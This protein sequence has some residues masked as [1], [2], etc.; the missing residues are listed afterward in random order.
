[1]PDC[2]A[3]AFQFSR[4]KYRCLD[5]CRAPFSFVMQYRHGGATRGQAFLLGAYHGAF[6]VG[7][8]WALML[9]MFAVLVLA[10]VAV[11]GQRL[12]QLRF[13]RPR[14][15]IELQA[16]ARVGADGALTKRDGLG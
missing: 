1:M 8:C 2:V 10:D 6:C 14:R 16:D 7:C 15:R 5:K 12:M 13:S 11:T 4:L 3:G 9:L